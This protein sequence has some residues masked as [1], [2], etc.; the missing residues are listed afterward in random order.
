[1]IARQFIIALLAFTV[2]SRLQAQKMES[3]DS[4]TSKSVFGFNLGLN[5]S[6]Y[7]HRSQGFSLGVSWDRRLNNY[8]ILRPQALISFGGDKVRDNL[9]VESTF[10]EIP[11]HLMVQDSRKKIAPYLVCGPSLKMDLAARSGVTVSVLAGGGFGV[12]W[13]LQYCSI[14]PEFRISFGKEIQSVNFG[15]NFKG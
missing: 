10:L 9:I 6:D 4:S 2:F 11:L 1:M 12:E 15:I 3:V 7:F 8:F 13:K 14:A 5:T